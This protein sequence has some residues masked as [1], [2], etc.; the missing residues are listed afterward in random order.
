MN[1]PLNPFDLLRRVLALL[2]MVFLLA[3]PIAQANQFEATTPSSDFGGMESRILRV[4]RLNFLSFD[5]LFAYAEATAPNILIGPVTAGQYLRNNTEY[6]YRFYEGSGNYLAIDP[7]GVIYVMGKYTDDKVLTIGPASAFENF[8][9]AWKSREP[10]PTKDAAHD[11]GESA[12]GGLVPPTIGKIVAQTSSLTTYQ[13]LSDDGLVVGNMIVDNNGK[14]IASER[15][16]ATGEAIELVPERDPYFLVRGN[17]PRIVAREIDDD[18]S[19]GVVGL[20]YIGADGVV[21]RLEI[22]PEYQG[23]YRVENGKFMGKN[24]L[25]LAP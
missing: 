18:E 22:V 16:N 17:P 9:S 3:A 6:N 11:V 13:L 4:V 1:S 23:I 19:G 24:G 25:P 10:N 8:V 5:Q 15:V 20:E 7:A 14:M 12:F 21:T 2:A